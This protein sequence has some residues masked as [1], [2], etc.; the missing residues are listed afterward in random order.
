MHQEEDW[1]DGASS[2]GREALLSLHPPLVLMKWELRNRAEVRSSITYKYHSQA[3]QRAMWKLHRSDTGTGCPTHWGPGLEHRRD[4]SAHFSCPG[5]GDKE[6][7]AAGNQT[8]KC[9]L[10]SSSK[11]NTI[12][13]LN[14]QF[15]QH[16]PDSKNVVISLLNT[17]SQANSL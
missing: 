7:R 13:E 14:S 11:T 1:K 2:A 10:M 5:Y 9:T 6:P 15:S 8:I 17:L 3:S 16:F 4:N 12:G